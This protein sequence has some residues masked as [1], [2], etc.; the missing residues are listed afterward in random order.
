MGVITFGFM[1]PDRGDEG[2][3]ELFK[4]LRSVPIKG[5][6]NEGIC[7]LASFAGDPPGDCDKILSKK[8]GKTIRKIRDGYY[9]SLRERNTNIKLPDVQSFF[10]FAF[11]EGVNPYSMFLLNP[12]EIIPP[13]PITSEQILSRRFPI[14][15]SEWVCDAANREMPFIEKVFCDFHDQIIVPL[16]KKEPYDALLIAD[17]IAGAF[18]WAYFTGNYWIQEAV[19]EIRDCLSL[20]GGQFDPSELSMYQVRKAMLLESWADVAKAL[21]LTDTF[22]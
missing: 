11:K 14:R 3:A 6:A 22:E 17:A 5:F 9:S 20:V 21:K 12:D 4:R 1:N 18:L 10:L 15:G 13:K 16:A 19:K 2:N 7:S 8:I